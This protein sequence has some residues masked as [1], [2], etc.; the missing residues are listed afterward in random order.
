MR[1]LKVMQRKHQ[2]WAYRVLGPMGTQPIT[3]N[4]SRAKNYGLRKEVVLDYM[5]FKMIVR[6]EIEVMKTWW[7]L[8]SR[9]KTRGIRLKW[10][11]LM[12]I[13]ADRLV[14]Q[15]CSFCPL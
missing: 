6:R 15:V 2:R 3:Y 13:A 5:L 9:K 14:K 12:D 11:R 1:L 4:F 10:S 8:K 7:E